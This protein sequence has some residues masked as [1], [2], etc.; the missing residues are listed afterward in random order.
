MGIVPG[1]N[2]GS[3]IDTYDSAKESI[4]NVEIQLFFKKQCSD[5][6]PPTPPTQAGFLERYK[7][8]RGR[9]GVVI[10]PL[11]IVD[12]WEKI[13]FYEGGGSPT[14]KASLNPSPVGSTSSFLF[15]YKQIGTYRLQISDFTPFRACF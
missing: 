3:H 13:S 1:A 8:K 12:S 4:L 14:E 10:T 5:L 11:Y 2:K 6:L 9:G 15:I 7:M